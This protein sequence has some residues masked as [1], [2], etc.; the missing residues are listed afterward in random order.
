MA[1]LIKGA[2]RK[3]RPKPSQARPLSRWSE[4]GEADGRGREWWLESEAKRNETLGVGKTGQRFAVASQQQIADS[5]QPDERRQRPSHPHIRWRIGA[6]GMD[7]LGLV[8]Y[9]A[10]C[11]FYSCV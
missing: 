9:A 4:V 8:D 10:V 3:S 1:C 5:A 11:R 2:C 6:A 7:V